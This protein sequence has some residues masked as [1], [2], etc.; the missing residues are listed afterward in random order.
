MAYNCLEKE[1]LLP[2]TKLRENILQKILGN[3]LTRDLF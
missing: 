3:N 2:D 1:E